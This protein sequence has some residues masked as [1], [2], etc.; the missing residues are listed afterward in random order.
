MGV[1]HAATG[2][3]GR[4]KVKPPAKLVPNVH[5]RIAVDVHVISNEREVSDGAATIQTVDIERGE[6]RCDDESRRVEASPASLICK[7]IWESSPKGAGVDERYECSCYAKSEVPENSTVCALAILVTRYSR[8]VV[9]SIKIEHRGRV[10]PRQ[11][12]GEGAGRTT[13]IRVVH[14]R[15]DVRDAGGVPRGE[16]RSGIRLYHQRVCTTNAPIDSGAGAG[17]GSESHP[18]RS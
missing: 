16:D 5:G 6:A 7:L 9:G 17:E 14:H 18:H 15:C 8:R 4:V 12:G 2:L 13:S 10:Q 1:D 11:V 3:S